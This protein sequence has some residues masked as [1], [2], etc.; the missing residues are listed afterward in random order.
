MNKLISS[1]SFYVFKYLKNMR[2]LIFFNHPVKF[3]IPDPGW[4]R[5]ILN[6]LF[7]FYVNLDLL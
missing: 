6:N 5:K 1:C 4:A 7:Y 2:V 3:K